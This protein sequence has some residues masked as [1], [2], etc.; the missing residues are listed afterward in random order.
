[1]ANAVGQPTSSDIPQGVLPGTQPVS[2][3]FQS[4]GPMSKPAGAP[5]MLPGTPGPM[6]SQNPIFNTPI[7]SI[8]G[9]G[10][11]IQ[12]PSSSGPMS[13]QNPALNT[14]APESLSQ[15]AQQSQQ[16]QQQTQQQALQQQQQQN[17]INA[18]IAQQVQSSSWQY[19][20][21]ELDRAF[22]K[23]YSQYGE[24]V[25]T[26]KEIKEAKTAVGILPV[27]EP[28]N[29]EKTV[30]T[31]IPGAISAEEARKMGTEEMNKKSSFF[32]SNKNPVV[33]LVETGIQKGLSILGLDKV[34]LTTPR[35]VIPTT[36]TMGGGQ[37]RFIEA[38][39]VP[40]SEV[41]GKIVEG[42]AFFVPVLGEGLIAS[43]A[44]GQFLTPQGR[45]E[46]KEASTL[47]KAALVG[48]NLLG[49][50]AAGTSAL[51]RTEKALGLPIFETRI[52]EK[53]LL[54]EEGR[55]VYQ[56][57]AT[58][59][60]KGLMPD[61]QFLTAF[62]SDIRPGMQIDNTQQFTSASLFSTREVSPSISGTAFGKPS[63]YG[64]LATG[65]AETKPLTLNLGG[66]ISKEFEQGTL[67][68]SVG[69]SIK[70]GETKFVVGDKSVTVGA[71]YPKDQ[72][73]NIFF[74]ETIGAKMTPEGVAF[75]KAGKTFSTGVAKTKPDFTIEQ[76]TVSTS[77]TQT[78]VSKTILD[79]KPL[80]NMEVTSAIEKNLK[81]GAV[82]KQ[83]STIEKAG[84]VVSS[85]GFGKV[86]SE[87]VQQ[88]QMQTPIIKLSTS[89]A[90]QQK[91][92]ETPKL[93][94]ESSTVQTQV[95]LLDTSTQTKQ[96]TT[97]LQ[98]PI[99]STAQQQT[100]KQISEQLQIPRLAT[101]TIET[102]I[103]K[104]KDLDIAPSFN[105][106]KRIESLAK[107]VKAYKTYLESKGKKTY[108]PGL[109]TIGEAEQLGKMKVLSQVRFKTF[110]VEESGQTITSGNDILPDL[111]QFREGIIRGGRLIATP[112]RFI[113][114][115][116]GKNPLEF[117]PGGR[118]STS[119]E[120]RE[121]QLLK[122]SK[123]RKGKLV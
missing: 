121:I 23:P 29:V 50:A 25:Y 36:V 41:G 5:A 98:I 122:R 114:K 27:E 107:T 10:T 4:S 116:G 99:L 47:G 85:S 56:G 48:G 110:G 70:P 102:R 89:Q 20:P 28:K 60:Q 123:S 72:N 17:I 90:Q 51:V 115:K 71:V 8:G 24:R 58:T 52:F 12:S 54:Q 83:V 3:P 9:S 30:S 103:V 40:I 38:T 88:K 61:K 44:G 7:Q 112:G 59:T 69:T 78:Q 63:I 16:Q 31:S 96:D 55:S 79:T 74:S 62:Y 13:S 105:S 92:I 45:Q 82:A 6:S 76:T 101:T 11:V 111:R 109:R 43:Y 64:E 77:G 94:L 57:V 22:S 119:A 113:E 35:Q 91:Q 67:I 106:K 39:K 117:N 87:T 118:L 2:N 84:N 73:Y 33:F 66:G 75:E 49:L 1:M 15:A 46:I 19:K 21:N 86:V 104:P 93:S 65:T 14:A 120:R 37:E 42:S 95:P 34:Y 100:P 97:Q 32:P 68:K 53:P 26:E 80:V 81:T 108:L 18:Q